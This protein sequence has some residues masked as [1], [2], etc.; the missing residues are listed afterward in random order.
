[1]E[2][3]P[4]KFLMTVE[5]LDKLLANLTN[6]LNEIP[7]DCK[8]KIIFDSLCWLTTTPTSGKVST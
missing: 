8:E 7:I 4:N 6:K 5:E 2:S 1:M 3:M